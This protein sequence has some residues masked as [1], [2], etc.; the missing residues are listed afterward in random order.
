[1]YKHFTNETLG[2]HNPK[3]PTA[4]S[5]ENLCYKTD[6]NSNLS[7]NI[8]LRAFAFPIYQSAF[9][10]AEFVLV[11]GFLNPQNRAQCVMEGSSLKLIDSV[12]EPKSTIFKTGP[13]HN[14]LIYQNW[15]PSH[16]LFL[17][18]SHHCTGFGIEYQYVRHVTILKTRTVAG[19]AAW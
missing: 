2:F 11:I 19:L 14:V 8:I 16:T 15:I 6:E 17:I 13:Y 12:R 4:C 5:T 18:L 10:N 9:V 1:M 7:T 3:Q